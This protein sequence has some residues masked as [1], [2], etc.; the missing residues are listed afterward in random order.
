[1][2]NFGRK[3]IANLIIFMMLFA[4]FMPIGLGLISYAEENQNGI[5]YSVKFVEITE[6]NNKNYKDVEDENSSTSE[7]NNQEENEK[8]E[9]N[10]SQEEN[11][12]REEV[13]KQEDNSNDEENE[14]E[15]VSEESE[16]TSDVY[17]NESENLSLLG[18]SLGNVQENEDNKIL[19]AEPNIEEQE[20]IEIEQNYDVRLGPNN[21]ETQEEKSLEEVKEITNNEGNLPLGPAIE[22]RV[23][24]NDSGYLKNGKVEIKDYES[25][26]FTIREDTNKDFNIYSI[27]E[28]KIKLNQING[29]REFIAYVPIELKELEA[30]DIE[31]I[32]E[33][34]LFNFTASHV[35]SS[36]YEEIVSL[37]TKAIMDLAN[38]YSIGMSAFIEKFI[39]YVED[40]QRN[41]LVQIKA[42]GGKA[43]IQ[44]LP[45]KSTT[46]EI[47]IPKL[48]GTE[49]ADLNVFA[50]ST[51]YTN[52]L[53]DGEVQFTVEDWKYEDGKIIIK[54]ENNPREDLYYKSTGDDEFIVFFKYHNCPEEEDVILNSNITMMS[55]VYTGVGITEKGMQD[56]Y[57]FSLFDAN[58]NI[59]TYEVSEKTKEI[60]KGYLFGNLNKEKDEEVV[61]VEYEN[62]L[63]IN[64]SRAD[65]LKRVFITEENEYYEDEIGNKYAT[66][67]DDEADSFY[68]EIKLNKESIN[69][70][71]GESGSI[72]L[73]TIEG[74][75]LITITKDTPEDGDG[76][77]RVGF[78]DRVVDKL[79][80]IINNPAEDG[81]L[82]ITAT[83]NIFRTLYNKGELLKFKAIVA[84]YGAKAELDLGIETDMGV[85]NVVTLLKDT[86]SDVDVTLSKNDISTLV[87]NENVDISISL[88]NANDT[89]DM[90]S[91]PIFELVFPEEIKDVIV[92][93]YNLLYGN[94]ELS[95]LNVESLKTSQGNCMIRV[96]MSGKQT[97]YTAGDSE[98]G[99][100]IILN[101]IISSNEYQA[102]K[103]SRLKMSYV[104]E[105]AT[106]YGIYSNLGMEIDYIPQSF[107]PFIGYKETDLNIVAPE[108]LVD[109]QKYYNYNGQRTVM[110]ANQGLKEDNIETFA[111]YVI[112]KAQLISINNSGEN[113]QDY[114]ILGRTPFEGNTTIIGEYPLGSNETAPMV[115]EIKP[116]STNN[117][118]YDIYYSTNATAME[119]LSEP[120]YGWTKDIED[121]RTV[122]SYLIV[123]NEDFIEG[124]SITF[125]YDFEIPSNLK[126][127]VDI[128]GTFSSSYAFGNY[129]DRVEADKVVLSTG[130]APLIDVQT[131]AETNVEQA[132]EG[133]RIKY[134]TKI[135]NIGRV[136][137]KN[138]EITSN[139]PEGTTLVQNDV[140]NTDLRELKF[141]IPEIKAGEIEYRT[142]EVEVN[143]KDNSAD[144]IEPVTQL[145]VDGI[146]NRIEVSAD[147]PLAIEKA[148]VKLSVKADRT[149][150]LIGENEKI[151][152]ILQVANIDA[153]DLRDCEIVANIPDGLEILD[154]YIEEYNNGIATKGI[155]GN[156]D[157]TSGKVFWNVDKID[158]FKTFKIE[159]RTKFIEESTKDISLNFSLKSSSLKNEYIANELKKTIGKPILQAKSYANLSGMYVKEGEALQYVLNLK[160]VGGIEATKLNLQN[161]V[162][163]EFA[164]TDLFYTKNGETFSGLAIQN[165]EVN[166]NLKKDEEVQVVLNCVAKNLKNNELE[167]LTSNSWF[168]SGANI[169]KTPTENVQT[170]VEQNPNVTENTYE[171]IFASNIDTNSTTRRYEVVLNEEDME[172]QVKKYKIIG[173]AFEDLNKNGE[174]DASEQVMSNVV[175]KL[176]DATTQ[177]IVSQT[178][179]NKAGEYVFEDLDAGDYYIKFEFDKD[180]YAVTS[181]KKNG[182]RENKNSDAI[183]SNGKAV[184]DKIRIKDKSVSDMNIGLVKAG[185]FD[186]ELDVNVN[187]M[188]I[189]EDGKT[190]RYNMENSKLAKIDISAKKVDN[191][192][193]IAE[194]AINVS[195]KGE[196]AGYARQ[197]KCALADG[198]SL[199]T[200][201]NP[202]WYEGG[203]GFVYTT[204][205]NNKLINPG[206]TVSLK[207]YLFK[208]NLKNGTGIYSNN[209]EIVKD[210]NEH[211]I[212]DAYMGN[213]KSQADFIIGIST[214]PNILVY[215]IM[216]S[217]SITILMIGLI[218]TK[219]LIDL[220]VV[221]NAPFLEEDT[222]IDETK[223][224]RKYKLD[225]ILIE[226]ENLKKARN[227]GSKKEKK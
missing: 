121:F 175:A 156:I 201:I 183:N 9:E 80:F 3:V 50:L 106:E 58:K 30:Y 147:R 75:S 32:Q 62:T 158:L 200:T 77:I 68:K 105:D 97:E 140:L 224:V 182:I 73:Q 111:D 203:D 54:I 207:L 102:S 16:T 100:T 215:T 167:K 78:G 126:N 72:E 132:V 214:G 122:K 53:S 38:D 189:S 39:P 166:L 81:I 178:V 157:I 222:I 113:L 61:P 108:G 28:N 92:G 159:A 14:P 116:V 103:K 130:E 151:T 162:P 196:I 41:A 185:L 31:S 194:Y 33:G 138:L 199:D 84:E 135:S 169:S 197:I 65:M 134:T 225:K 70:I 213:N 2:K 205:L 172:E 13:D 127:E 137:A 152:Y 66:R 190:S 47:E 149:E 93:D 186:L 48:E 141:T 150:D 227:K 69:N 34:T 99:T 7:N 96:T 136:T 164:V 98:K 119:D 40:N 25:Q 133:Q 211:A 5:E 26:I 57:Q 129:I 161:S 217:F 110:S 218:M 82:N 155:S 76:Y 174:F 114:K 4:D 27:N 206:E 91:N 104:N 45:V 101:C 192:V 11:E 95:I 128:V 35:S 6:E 85:T 131:Y 83:K 193:V 117:Y 202:V 74:E 37:S 145:K 43:G 29:N 171:N 210:Y 49:V 209:F 187:R 42:V 165:A 18:V 124:D 89:S 51:A 1:M 146:E 176:C 88:N 181:Y 154:S 19:V 179:T 59:I 208:D 10:N 109:I 112:A 118:T 148:E 63:N 15:V 8:Q 195:N 67:I 107:L 23:K 44:T 120:E 21:A 125:E 52:G 153:R 212:S 87:A 173:F 219:R 60:S 22:I 198:L 24:L 55:E 184:T 115:G 216:I 160:N 90:Y 142:F 226:K 56:N 188:A 64:I 139:V 79:I 223:L 143:A 71:L 17:F 94:D 191:A 123:L 221:S 12:N 20:K 220:K 177:S 46:Y 144:F 180:Y 168:I 170:I 204:A 86:I 163:E 36:S